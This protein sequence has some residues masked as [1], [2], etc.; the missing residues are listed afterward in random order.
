[1]SDTGRCDAPDGV[2]YSCSD[3]DCEHYLPNNMGMHFGN[4]KLLMPFQEDG[5]RFLDANNGIGFLN[6]QPGTGK[7]WGALGLLGLR[8][9]WRPA[10]IVSP[11]VMKYKW[12]AEA[13][14][15]LETDDVIEVIKNGKPKELTG[16]III[17]QG[18]SSHHTTYNHLIY[19]GY[20]AV[21]HKIRSTKQSKAQIT[22]SILQSKIKMGSPIFCFQSSKRK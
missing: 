7:T 10:V 17:T 15:L 5:I 2:C 16:N 22:P 9:E 14:A 11:A 3:V 19:S 13:L 12:E 20:K 1:M 6:D 21:Q 8:P 18:H 4:G